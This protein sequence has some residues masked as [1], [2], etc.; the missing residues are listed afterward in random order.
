MGK[1]KLFKEIGL[2]VLDWGQDQFLFDS[3]S[4]TK[5]IVDV[6]K[7][8]KLS[9]PLDW[10]LKNWK[11]YYSN[12]DNIMW[13]NAIGNDENSSFY[14]PQILYIDPL[15]HDNKEISLLMDE[16]LF[17]PGI[18]SEKGFDFYKC[19][20]GNVTFFNGEIARIS[21]WDKEKNELTFQRTSYFDYLKTNL[22]LDSSM[23][24]ALNSM[25]LRE[26]LHS[27]KTVGSLEN[28]KLANA[29]GING[30]VFTSDG[31]II[32]QTRS[33]AVLVRPG[34][35]CS[36]FSGTIDWDDITNISHKENLNLGD[37]DVLREMT[38]ELA[39]SRN[40]QEKEIK[41]ITFLGLTGELIRGGTP[42]LF[43]SVDLNISAK[44]VLSR[45]PRDKEGKMNTT[46]WGLY[47][48][49]ILEESEQ[50]TLS[51]NF[52]NLLLSLQ[53]GHK[54]RIS[55]PFITNLVLWL[56]VNSPE[57]V[58]FRNTPDEVKA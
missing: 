40:I 17:K 44:E 56:Y 9:T 51:Q 6:I 46:Y 15:K 3:F 37:L 21:K 12:Q 52:N 5:R 53:K 54:A 49:S 25:N 7:Q 41:N 36:G 39:V 22:S 4:L 2:T 35:L 19:I 10:E 34:Q 28:S 24:K 16:K 58:E 57:S 55:I 20:N 33:K 11:E 50:E 38:E 31:H 8:N 43:Y 18:T 32:F 14:I 48:K 26:H 1:L 29:V 23:G 42:E 27:K 30:L 47:A 45:I 13:T